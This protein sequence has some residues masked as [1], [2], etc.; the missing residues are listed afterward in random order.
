MFRWLAAAP[1][2]G[3]LPREGHDIW[4]AYH[5]PRYGGWRSDEVGAGALGRGERRF[6]GAFLRSYFGESRFVEKTPE[7]SFRVP[8]LLDL[9]PDARFLVV[10]R[11]PVATIRS[12]ING[13]RDPEGRFRSYFVP[14]ELRIPGYPHRHQWCFGL[15]EGWR[16]L[17]AATIPEIACAQWAAFADALAEAKEGVSDGRW[18]EIRLED[19]LDQP[20]AIARK[21]YDF[22]EISAD[23]QLEG[24]LREMTANP[25]YA[26]PA[27]SADAE[28]EVE[29]CV[30]RLAPR[31]QKTGY[32]PE[33]REGRWT[34][35]REDTDRP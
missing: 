9:F 6:V 4:R 32:L 33:R 18:M 31:I 1:G 30:E 11:S 34:V 13:W 25:V 29:G 17:T 24:A 35:R 12:I 10:R 3:S 20:D 22:A 19:W 7:N 15:I 26:S 8:Y 23:D 5:H 27:T 2:F 28:T 16:D 21:V 14:D